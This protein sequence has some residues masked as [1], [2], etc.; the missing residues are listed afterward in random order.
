MHGDRLH[1]AAAVESADGVSTELRSV[2]VGGGQVT[3]RRI[4]GAYQLSAWPW[5]LSVPGSG[6]AA[7]PLELRNL[8]TDQR[9]TVAS[10]PSEYVACS[11]TWCRSIVTTGS[12]GSTRYDIMRSDGTGRRR[13]GGA[14]FSAA[15]ADVALLDRFEPVLEMSNRTS[16]GAQQRLVL[17]DVT[18]GRLVTVAE[19]VRE[20]LARQHV[21]WWS[22]GDRQSQVWHSVDLA[23]LV[24]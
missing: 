19:N 7:E 14:V 2:P 12:D 24:P 13:V 16:G 1:W 5:L 10:S 4:T 9:V 15:V 11:P 22:T 3:V 21:L 18:T 8:D 23:T 17:Y 6:P 20:V